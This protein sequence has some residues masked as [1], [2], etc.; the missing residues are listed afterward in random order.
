M[1]NRALPHRQR[2]GQHPD[3]TDDFACGQ[4]P[5]E[6]H[7]AGEAERAGHRAAYLRRNA[8]GHGR[9][10]GNE[11]RFDPLAVGQAKQELLRAIDR[12]F[13]MD[14]L[15]RRHQSEFGG[16]LLAQRAR[17]IGHGRQGSQIRHPVPVDPLEDLVRPETMMSARREGLLRAE[18]SRPARSMGGARHGISHVCNHL[19]DSRS[20]RGKGVIGSRFR[21]HGDPPS[22][23]LFRSLA[24]TGGRVL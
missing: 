20:Y 18:R 12:A 19:P 13:A 21:R 9:G 23:P 8:E 6:P 14:E 5:R 17:H 16:Q 7:L 3:L 24:P 22:R 4:I 15:R 10:I 1:L 11:H 2:V